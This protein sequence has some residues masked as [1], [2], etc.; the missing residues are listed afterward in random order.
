LSAFFL[1]FPALTQCGV[2]DAPTSQQDS[3]P[4]I[5]RRIAVG[6]DS[7][8]E[9]AERKGFVVKPGIFPPKKNRCGSMCLEHALGEFIGIYERPVPATNSG[10][11]SHCQNTVLERFCDGANDASIG[12]NVFAASGHP[13]GTLHVERGGIYEN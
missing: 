11:T 9:L 4:Q 3:L 8:E 1:G 12:Q 13:S 10:C 2:E 6:G 5:E 7:Q